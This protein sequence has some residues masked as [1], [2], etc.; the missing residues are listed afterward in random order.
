MYPKEIIGNLHKQP[1]KDI[2]KVLLLCILKTLKHPKMV[3]LTMKVT[4]S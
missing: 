3:K 1:F 4:F 2:L